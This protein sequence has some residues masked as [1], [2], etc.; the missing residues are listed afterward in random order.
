[1]ERWIEA[2]TDHGVN[3]FIFDWYWFN[4]GPFLEGC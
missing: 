4:N 2:A 3:T 1:M